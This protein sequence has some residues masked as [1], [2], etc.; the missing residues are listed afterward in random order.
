M[1]LQDRL[2]DYHLEGV[3]CPSRYNGITRV[4][5]EYHGNVSARSPTQLGYSAGQDSPIPL[6]EDPFHISER[7]GGP[8]PNQSVICL[9]QKTNEGTFSRPKVRRRSSFPDEPF[10]TA[11]KLTK[12]ISSSVKSASDVLQQAFEP[13]KRLIRDDPNHGFQKL[14][15]K[16]HLTCHDYL[17]DEMHDLWLKSNQDVADR[18]LCRGLDFF[19]IQ[20]LEQTER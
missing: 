4:K 5:R 12:V 19:T 11:V 3:N 17:R 15:E 18:G 10:L 20:W 8:I 14:M 2:C 7:N 6:E 9:P 13:Y 16:D 1:D